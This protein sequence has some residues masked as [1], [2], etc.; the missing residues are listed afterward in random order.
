MAILT[1]VNP[2]T[3]NIEY[4]VRYL[5]KDANGKRRD[6]KT[7]WF[8]TVEEAVDKVEELKLRRNLDS[9]SEYESRKDQKVIDVFSAWVYEL[10]AKSERATTENTTSDRTYFKRAKTVK[11]KYM[12]EFIRNLRVR[13]LDEA[14]F[15]MWLNDL[16]NKELSGTTVR[17]YKMCIVKFN[18]YLG[19]NGYYSDPELDH[20]I[21]IGLA[22][23]PIKPK[24]AGERKRRVP[25]VMDVENLVSYYQDMGLGEFKNFYWYTLWYTLFYS[26]LRISE[27]IGLQWKFVDLERDTL[28][29]RNSISEREFKNNVQNRVKQEIY[30]TKNSKSE[31]IIPIFAKYSQL[32]ADYRKSFKHHFEIDEKTLQNSFVFPLVLYSK[33]DLNDYQ[34]QKNILREL[35][36]V[37]KIQGIEKT[38]VQMMRHGCATWLV[39]DR[40]DGGLG[41]SE[42]QAKDYFGHTGDD[43][44]RET[45]AK[46]NKKQRARRTR[47]TF[48]SL[49]F[50]K[51]EEDPKEVSANKI[52]SDLVLHPEMKQENIDE[53][54]YLRI[55]AEI[56]E[57]IKNKKK[58]YVFYDDD[59]AEIG[60]I[61][62]DYKELGIDL[63]DLIDLIWEHKGKKNLLKK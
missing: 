48:K 63:L 32:L 55:K 20:R 40:E 2:K 41:F 9:V 5:W 33:E 28:D 1:R 29:I 49:M 42:S 43:L 27:L 54:R 10:E 47:T 44:L 15:R 26:G 12:P 39:M 17:N 16:N 11:E 50:D 23:V 24:N 22:R 6:S 51:P 38:D 58:S 56:R 46:I 3:H 18:Q 59:V 34:K 61:I 57:C 7:G 53:A 45:Y 19:N 31:R 36:R 30:H 21:D 4:R 37:C 52:Y 25:T 14:K 60:H 35:D 8:L 13:D 62:L